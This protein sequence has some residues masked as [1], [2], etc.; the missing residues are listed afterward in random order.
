M[1]NLY[2]FHVSA[3]VVLFIGACAFTVLIVAV[4]RDRHL[5][6]GV[7]EMELERFAT[8]DPEAER[9]VFNDWE[10]EG[11]FQLIEPDLADTWMRF[12]EARASAPLVFESGGRRATARLLSATGPGGEAA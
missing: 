7:P 3:D 6:S 5:T 9:P 4:T 1:I 11:W 8:Y 2:G 10:Q 12:E